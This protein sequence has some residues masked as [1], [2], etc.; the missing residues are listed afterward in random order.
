MYCP[1]CGAPNDGDQATCTN[2]GA[3]LGPDPAAGSTPPPGYASPAGYGPGPGYVDYGPRYGGFWKRFVA[4]IIDA[5]LIN[6]VTTIIGYAF[7]IGY[8]TRIGDAT[9]GRGA[10]Y[11]IVTI[12]IL[13][14]YY[15]LMESSSQQATLGKMALG[16]VVTDL[17]GNRISFGK[18]TIR[19]WGK[20]LSTIILLI[21]WIMAGFT[22][23]KQAL[24]DIIAGT[25]VINKR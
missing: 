8:L 12:V 23:R 9:A 2:C 6:I 25:L 16:M 15:A 7:G 11:G 17:N 13:W 19:F 22:A 21:G 18:A 4:Y 24:H 5:I 10:G 1:R 14:L 3:P 20:Y